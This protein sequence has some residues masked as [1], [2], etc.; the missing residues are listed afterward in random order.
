[1]I[2]FRLAKSDLPGPVF[3]KTFRGGMTFV[4]NRGIFLPEQATSLTAAAGIALNTVAHFQMWD[5]EIVE[6][7]PPVEEPSVLHRV[8]QR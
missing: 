6:I 5:G 8:R 4:L 3:V 1:M 7:G 2:N